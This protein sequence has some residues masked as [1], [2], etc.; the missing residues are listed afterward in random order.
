MNVVHVPVLVE[1]VLEF[2]KHIEG[3]FLDCTVGLGGHA[4]AIL[5]KIPNSVVVGLDVDEEALD[6]AKKEAR[7]IRTRGACQTVQEFIRGCSR[8]SE[9]SWF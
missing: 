6:L 5:S 2:F 3:V 8:G 1:E 4:E 7:A 9:G